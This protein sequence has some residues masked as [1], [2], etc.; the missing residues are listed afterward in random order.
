MAVMEISSPEEL[1]KM[2]ASGKPLVVEFT[3]DWCGNCK[4]LRR[5]F[6]NYAETLEKAGIIVVRICL[7]KKR[8]IVDDKK[9]TIFPTP[10]HSALREEFA[11]YGFPTV[12]FFMDG[13]LL[14]SSLEDTGKSYGKLVDYFLSRL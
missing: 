2:I 8:Q 10:E 9:K 3:A 7:S 5:H 14:A 1:K 13:R 12:G 11:K 4:N 6:E